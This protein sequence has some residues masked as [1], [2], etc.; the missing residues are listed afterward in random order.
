M[1]PPA[2]KKSPGTAIAL[3]TVSVVTLLACLVFAGYLALPKLAGRYLP[4]EKIR[5]LGFADFNG[6]ISRIGLYGAVAGP[7][8]FGHAD[9]PAIVIRSVELNYSPG[10]LRRKKIRRI[11]VDDLTVNALMTPHGIALPGMEKG[12]LGEKT[13]ADSSASGELLPGIG[14]RVGKIQV[15]S[16]RILLQ[17]GQSVYRIPFEADIA[18]EPSDP[19]KL[20]A[21]VRLFPGEQKAVLKVQFD[22]ANGIGALTLE[23]SAIHLDRFADLFHSVP[24]LDL[25]GTLRFNAAVQVQA[26][27][28]VFSDGSIDA[29]WQGGRLDVGNVSIVPGTDKNPATFSATSA[30]L[31]DWQIDASNLQLRTPAPVAVKALKTRIGLSGD[32]RIIAGQADLAVLPFS[33]RCPEAVALASAVSLPLTFDVRGS[34]SGAESG[35]WSAVCH[36]LQ[37]DQAGQKKNTDRS[38][39][40]DLTLAGVRLQSRVPR[41]QLKARIEEAEM[42]ASWQMVLPAIRAAAS[43]VTVRGASA[44]AEGLVTVKAPFSDT[45]WQAD[46]RVQLPAATFDGHALAGDLVDLEL[47]VDARQD[48][49]AAPV[50]RG[51][52]RLPDGR[53]EYGSAGIELSGIRLDLPYGF[54]TRTETAKGRFS[55][56]RMRYGSHLLGSLDG[57]ATRN[58]DG[59]LFSATHVSDLF[60]ELKAAIEGSLTHPESAAPILSLRMEVPPYRLA[61]GTDLGRLAPAMKGLAFSGTVSA[62]ATASVSG[63]GVQGTFDLSIADGLLE[64]AQ[65]KVR[66]EGI[67]ASVHFPELPRIRSAPAQT[68]RFTR[69]AVGSIVVDGGRFGFQVESPDSLLVEKGRLQWCGGKVDAQSLRIAA[70]RQDYQ[71]SLYCQRLGLSQILEQLGAVNAKGS[72]TV[73]GRIPVVYSK[74]SIRF[75]DGFLFSTPGEEGRIQLTGTEILTRGIPQGT[76]QFAQVELAR[77]ALKDYTYK[78]AKLGMTTEGET[79]VMRLQFDGKPAKPLPFVYKKEIGHFVRV[80]AGAQGSVFQ[81]ISLDVNLKLPLN[82]LLQYKDIVDMID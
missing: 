67:D 26:Q 54:N 59:Y 79:L 11:R 47:S 50:A 37:K 51:R 35:A 80:E 53:F 40:M 13:P 57:R 7:F 64:M 75:D 46:A 9:R 27:P 43:G 25:T 8:I 32:A 60:P 72:G 55:V 81:G 19:T 68:L 5:Q 45:V 65:K 36:T 66:V 29:A 34:G 62:G 41:F 73:N 56:Q 61:A 33:I 21:E 24:N 74:G 49:D 82:R 10:E 31:S 17:W 39:R 18:P 63:Q 4:V 77:E 3:T 2:P 69:A 44:R 78:W 12:R 23:G 48:A 28:L 52:L 42:Q 1:N 76:P 20:A 38:D 71:I 16:A 30:N 70:K 14:E 6:R 15:R 22:L 58:A